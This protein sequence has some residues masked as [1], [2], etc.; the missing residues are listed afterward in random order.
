MRRRCYQNGSSSSSSS[1]YKCNKTHD[2]PPLICNMFFSHRYSWNNF[3]WSTILYRLCLHT[4]NNN[5]NSSITTTTIIII[6][7]HRCTATRLTT[8]ICRLWR[9][10]TVY[11]RM[12]T[13]KVSS[14][15]F[16]SSIF[17]Y[18]SSKP[19]RRCCCCGRF[20]EVFYTAQ[21]QHRVLVAARP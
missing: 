18:F 15:V 16:S 19:S 3:T 13:F 8:T 21:P 1:C 6:I 2:D 20:L 9:P 17:C 12:I 10:W 4:N 5:S 14:N 11:C 7:H